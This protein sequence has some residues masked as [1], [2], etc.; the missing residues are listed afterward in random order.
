MDYRAYLDPG[1][2][3]AAVVRGYTSPIKLYQASKFLLL[4]FLTIQFPRNLQAIEMGADTLLIDE[5]TCATNF[6]IRDDKM[7]QLVAA[8]KEP[9]TPF[10]S[11][12]RSLYDDR[13]IS[14]ILVIGG[15]GDYFDVADNVIVMDCYKCIDMT[16]RA[17]QIVANSAK[18]SHT[19]SSSRSFKPIRKRT[20]VGNSFTANGKVKVLSK[21]KISYGETELDISFVEQLITKSQAATIS[22]I[23]QLLPTKARGNQTLQEMLCALDAHIDREGLDALSPGQ[24]HGGMSRPRTL[25]IGAAINRLRRPGAII[26]SREA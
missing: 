11:V 14:S 22:N 13:G 24:L 26:Q 10:V 7:V 15:V 18:A 3:Y 5:D 21:Q 20:V 17:K 25:E 8:E 16:E 23:L 19:S 6:M 1:A 9:I 4:Q 12:V 2:V